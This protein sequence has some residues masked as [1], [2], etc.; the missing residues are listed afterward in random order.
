M[1]SVA[2]EASANRREFIVDTP[3]VRKAIE[4]INKIENEKFPLLL[5]RIAQKLHTS[6]ESS[7]KQ[8]EMEKLEASLELS[9]ENLLAAIDLLEFIYLQSAYE[10][11]KPAVLEAN[12]SKLSFEADKLIAIV[13]QWKE[14][15]KEII[16]RI[17]A[18]RTIYYQRLKSINWRLN[19]QLATNNRTKMKNPNAILEFNISAQANTNLAADQKVQVEYNRDQLYDFFL[20]LEG[21]QRQLDGLN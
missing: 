2:T 1:S 21:I 13:S 19:L 4:I 5:Q 18:S 17:R 3:Q 20:K 14:N 7:F 10:L 8:E 6:T 11:V 12:L 16:E 9:N 15:G